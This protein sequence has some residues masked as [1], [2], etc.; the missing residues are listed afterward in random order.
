[1]AG[2][3]T[4]TFRVEEYKR[5]TFH[6]DIQPL[7]EEVAFGDTVTLTGQAQS[8]AGVRLTEGQVTWRILR[9]P[10]WGWRGTEGES[11][12]AEGTT[13]LNA[14]GRFQMRFCPTKRQQAPLWSSCER[15][16][17][18]AIVTDSKGESQETTYAFSVGESSLVL[19]PQLSEQVEKE[20]AK[21]SI[22]IRTLNG[23]SYAGTGRYQLKALQV[24]DPTAET[25]TFQEGETVLSGTFTGDQPLE[26]SLLAQL[27]SGRYRLC[28]EATDRQ[29]RTSRNQSDF[30]L[31]SRTD[32]RPPYFLHTWLLKTI[33]ECLPG[34]NAELVF[35][36]SDAPS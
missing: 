34:E 30:T 31:Y 16:E 1:M 28:A 29:R 4:Y 22:A 11:Q 2:K 6:A 27:P 35:G 24:M 10:F 20:Q 8:F 19:L 5:P 12:V 13:S 17:L 21:I 14:E 15:Y 7:Q 33:T 26:T 18:Q 9:R 23:E 36:T 32:N 25:I 3:H